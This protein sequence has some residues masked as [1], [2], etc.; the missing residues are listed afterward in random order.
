MYIYHFLIFNETIL[1]E[2]IL[3]FLTNFREF[4]RYAIEVCNRKA[5]VFVRHFLGANFLVSR[6]KLVCKKYWKDE[7]DAEIYSLE[8]IVQVCH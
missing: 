5:I 7:H 2:I 8:L 3:N 4:K 1:L 6:K